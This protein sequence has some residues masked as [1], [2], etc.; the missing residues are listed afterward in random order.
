MR[1]GIHNTSMKMCGMDKD[2]IKAAVVKKLG[3]G[4]QYRLKSVNA[5]KNDAPKSVVCTL[6]DFH[7]NV[8]IFKHKNN[9]L[10]DFTYQEIWNQMKNGDFT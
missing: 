6:M 5:A 1:T 2:A 3:I 10:E 7:Q 8:V 4:Q 9:M